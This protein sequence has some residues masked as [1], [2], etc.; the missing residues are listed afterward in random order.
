MTP[1]QLNFAFQVPFARS[2]F[3][4]NKGIWWWRRSSS[5]TGLSTDA[6]QDLKKEHTRVLPCPQSDNEPSTLYVSACNTFKAKIAVRAST[7][8]H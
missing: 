2:L 3:E 1:T 5:G 7:Y 8:T 6:M 4:N